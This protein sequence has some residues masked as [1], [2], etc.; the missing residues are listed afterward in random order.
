[1]VAEIV[2][3]TLGVAEVVGETEA[4]TFGLAEAVAECRCANVR[5]FLRHALSIN[6]TAPFHTD[7]VVA[8]TMMDLCRRLAQVRCLALPRDSHQHE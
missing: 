1:M 5:Y 3:E 8:I 2:G 4:E 7:T 6:A